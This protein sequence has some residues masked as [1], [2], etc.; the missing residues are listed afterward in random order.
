[1]AMKTET[2]IKNKIIKDWVLKFTR[3]EIKSKM[4]LDIHLATMSECIELGIDC[5]IAWAEVE[6][7]VQEPD[8]F[9]IWCMGEAWKMTGEPARVNI[10]S[11]LLMKELA[12]K[13]GR[14]A[15]L[16]AYQDGR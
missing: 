14:E 3:E 1:M 15:L 12:I 11:T 16:K 4:P 7:V 9:W 10:C 6:K 5:P 2:E 13:I 8:G